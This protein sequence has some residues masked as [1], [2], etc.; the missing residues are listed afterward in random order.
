LL[1]SL[2][3][4]LPL[5]LGACRDRHL[6]KEE[7]T[8]LLDH[9]IDMNIAADPT[10]TPLPE[11]VSTAMKE[12]KKNAIKVDVIYHLRRE[13]CLAEVR[14]HEY[15]CALATHTPNDWEACLD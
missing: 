13:Q 9:Y 11:D 14:W 15:T 1:V 2:L 5:T 4:T 8:Q 10:L 7:C 12:A 6:S 3:V